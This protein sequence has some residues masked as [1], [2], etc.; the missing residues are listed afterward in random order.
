[1]AIL[2]TTDFARG[3]ISFLTLIVLDHTKSTLTD[4]QASSLINVFKNGG[5]GPSKNRKIY[6][7]CSKNSG[8]GLD[9]VDI[10]FIQWATKK[11]YQ[12]Q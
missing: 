3:I 10:H 11:I 2:Y 6:F 4:S 7:Q 1:M 12:I 8:K 9:V 5:Q